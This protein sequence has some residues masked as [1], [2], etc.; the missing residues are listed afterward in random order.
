MGRIVAEPN[1]GPQQW[2]TDRAGLGP[3][4]SEYYNDYPRW[5]F[6]LNDRGQWVVPTWLPIMLASAFAA[7]P[8]IPWST[9]FSI[10]A[11]LI[12]TTFVAAVLGLFVYSM[13]K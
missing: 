2:E 9:R 1:I 4:G 10:R 5:E 7:A 6:G 13:S 11:I 8:W 12:L 3:E